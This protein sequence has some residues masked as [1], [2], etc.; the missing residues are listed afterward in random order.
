MALVVRNACRHGFSTVTP[1]VQLSQSMDDISEKVR[2]PGNLCVFRCACAFTS[3]AVHSTEIA[4]KSVTYSQACGVRLGLLPS[5][6]R[7]LGFACRFFSRRSARSLESRTC[8]LTD[9]RQPYARPVLSTEQHSSAHGCDAKQ[10]L[11]R[12]LSVCPPARPPS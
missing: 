1:S 7:K 5:A 2:C 11:N 6:P 8:E 12:S 9:G 3:K 4:A 10:S